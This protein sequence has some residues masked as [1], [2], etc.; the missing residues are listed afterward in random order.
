MTL[1]TAETKGKD[2]ILENKDILDPEVIPDPD[3]LNHQI[4][5]NNL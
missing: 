1:N 5:D 4:T 3:I 2:P